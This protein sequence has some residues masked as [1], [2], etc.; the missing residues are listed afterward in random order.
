KAA[1]VLNYGFDVEPETF[2]F[3]RVFSPGAAFTGQNHFV[4]FSVIGMARDDKKKPS[5][6]IRMQVLDETGKTVFTQASTIP[7]DLPEE[8]L[9]KVAPL[10]FIPLQYGMF[11]NRPGRFTV[12]LEGTD[13]LGKKSAKVRIPFTVVDVSS[14]GSK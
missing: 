1:K 2:G 5:V 11:L 13:K 14:L 12:E 7:K 6:D 10:P 9:S 3:V 8:E 4:N